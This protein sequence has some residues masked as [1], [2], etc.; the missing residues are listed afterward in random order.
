MNYFTELLMYFNRSYD[1]ICTP[2]VSDWIS[3]ASIIV[4]AILAIWIIKTVQDKVNNKRILKDHLI[5]EIKE[6]RDE[7]RFFLNQL[8]SN[9]IKPSHIAPWFKLMNI[10]IN[11]LLDLISQKGSIDKNIL[12]P[13]QIELRDTI[14]ELDEYISNY[15][16]DEKI[17]LSPISQIKVI[18]FQQKYNHLFNKAIVKINK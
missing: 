4:N 1:C 10:K 8:F 17:L 6:V 3:I 12:N 7:Y 18:R 14:T 11:D 5:N 16:S 9:K 15:I 13:Y 2:E